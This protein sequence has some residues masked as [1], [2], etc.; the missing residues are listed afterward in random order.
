MLSA[1]LAAVITL[2]TAGIASAQVEKGK[3]VFTAQKCTICH[4]VGADG[5]KKGPLDGIGS[6]L[7]ADEIRQWI[8]NA[9]DMAAKAKSDRK[10]AMKPVTTL[11]KED[12]DALVAYVSS[13][14]K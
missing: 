3:A 6:K 4:A 5:N 9:P 7:S 14:K 8:T 10:P 1:A 11:E 12:L 2:G 13:L